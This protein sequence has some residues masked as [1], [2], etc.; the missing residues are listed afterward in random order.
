MVMVRSGKDLCKSS[1][2]GELLVVLLQSHNSH[3][4]TLLE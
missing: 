4:N 1:A 3:E 2:F